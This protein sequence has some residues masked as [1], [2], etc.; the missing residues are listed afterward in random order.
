MTKYKLIKKYPG[1]PELDTEVETDGNRILYKG[2]HS[3]LLI[4]EVISYPEFWQEVIEKDY[5]ILSYKHN[6]GQIAGMEYINACLK[7]AT[8]HE[9]WKIYSVKR[10][11]DGEIFTIGDRIKDGIIDTIYLSDNILWFIH[12]GKMTNS[13]LEDAIKIKKPLFTSEDGVD[14]FVDDIVYGVRP[15]YS[16]WETSSTSL[17]YYNDYKF[18]STEEAAKEYIL[19]NKPCLSIND[20]MKASSI[21]YCNLTALKELVK[22]KL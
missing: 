15:N 2:V 21:T 22:F 6:D 13:K 8:L 7:L 9:G 10:L 17:S 20:L 16:I 5:E 1:S 19:M 14:I 3:T 4:K 11:S 12:T 18:Y